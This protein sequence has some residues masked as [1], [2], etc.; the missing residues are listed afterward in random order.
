M[1]KHFLLCASTLL[2]LIFISCRNEVDS[3]PLSVKTDKIVDLRGSPFDAFPNEVLANENCTQLFLGTKTYKK[4]PPNAL[5]ADQQ[6][7]LSS[8]PEDIDKLHK[9]TKLSIT[10]SK[11]KTLPQSLKNMYN[12]KTLDIS[13]N[14]YLDTA[15]LFKIVE[16]I[17]RLDTLVIYRCFFSHQYKERFW[18]SNATLTIKDEYSDP[19]YIGLE[20]SK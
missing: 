20:L 4:Y 17:P 2:V 10:A 6:I 18:Q 8:V 19:E 15:A 16:S 9:L 11:L 14:S 3:L 13:F 12:L 1:K 5:V 7:E